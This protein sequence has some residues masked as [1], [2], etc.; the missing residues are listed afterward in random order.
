MVKWCWIWWRWD[1]IESALGNAVLVPIGDVG[2]VR[3]FVGEDEAMVMGNGDD[4]GVCAQYARRIHASRRMGTWLVRGR[5][6]SARNK[7]RAGGEARDRCRCGRILRLMHESWWCV[8]DGSNPF[9]A[10]YGR[11]RRR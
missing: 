8:R 10:G 2:R 1:F 5:A 11:R 7:G 3:P 4:G 9:R 6:R